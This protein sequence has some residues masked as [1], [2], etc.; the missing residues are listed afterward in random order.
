L[1]I[2]PKDNEAFYRE[3]DEELRR[4]KLD[5][6]WKRYGYAVIGGVVL[7]LALIAGILWW[8]HDK[9]KRA[10][11]QGE[12]LSQVFDD[13]EAGKKDAAIPVL[14]GLAKEGTPGYR[15]AALM[16]KADLAARDGNEAGAL[17]GFKT[18]A[19]DTGLPQ[20]YRDV[21]LLRQTAIEF[22]KL[23]PAAV[24]QRLQPLAQPGN[25]WFGSAGEMVA[26]AYLKQKQPQRAA[27]IFA[28]MAK[29]QTVPESI[30]QRATQMAGSLGTDTVEQAPAPVAGAAAKEVSE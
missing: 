19:A 29:D 14:D 30:R 12:Q 25:A 26:M 10:G 21:A 22:D 4:E 20:P 7:L 24:I 18:V 16:T 15:A 23:A 17:A 9:A 2:K 5:S 1:A 3:V 28:Q 27:A 11:V 8:Q 6:F 13:L